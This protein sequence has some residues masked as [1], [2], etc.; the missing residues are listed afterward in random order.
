MKKIH[1]LIIFITA[2]LL[3]GGTA[4]LAVDAK[5]HHVTRKQQPAPKK[6]IRL[7]NLNTTTIAE[8]K[9]LQ[10]I[11]L[12]KAAAIVAYREQHGPF[13]SVHELTNVKGI[14]EKIVAANRTRLQVAPIDNKH[15]QA[16]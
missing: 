10:G 8:L 1:I 11:G 15:K 2:L 16:P 5:Q 13:K 7:I 3:A 9:T 14:S 12:R 6:T 4:T